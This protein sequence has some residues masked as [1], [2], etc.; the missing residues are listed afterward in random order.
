LTK[1]FTNRLKEGKQFVAKCGMIRTCRGWLFGLCTFCPTLNQQR[2]I[3][4]NNR[5]DLMMGFS[6]YP[7]SL[8]RHWLSRVSDWLI[9]ANLD[10]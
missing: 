8:N 1:S 10:F 3:C 9:L 7:F 4:E 6:T 5:P 2:G